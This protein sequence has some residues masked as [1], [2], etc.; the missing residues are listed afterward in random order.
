MGKYITDF[1]S[2]RVAP[3]L[4]KFATPLFLTSLL[5]VFY[6]TVDMIIVGQ[7]LEDVG[8]SAVAVGGDVTLILAFIAMGFAAAGQVIISQLIGAG[9]RQEV[10]G[11]IGTMCTVLVGSAILFTV[12]GYVFRH[13]L[14]LLMNT[15]KEAYEEALGYSTVSIFGMVFIYGY[16]AASSVLR[17]MGDA[18]RPLVFIG[19]S[20]VINVILDIVFVVW[21][22]QGATGAA[23]ATVIS[24][25]VSLVLSIIYI[26]LKRRNY[27]LEFSLKNFLVEKRH[28]ERL[29]A[30]GIPMAIKSAAVQ[31]A[32]I[33]VNSFVNSFG[34][35]VSAFSGV[36][37]KLNGIS[38][39]FSNAFNTAGA[40]MVA[41]NIGAKKYDR[42]KSVLCT[43]G[44]ITCTIA[45]VFTLVMLIFPEFVY[46]MF[47]SNA[48]VIE[49]GYTYLPIA[50]LNF[51]ASALRAVA[52]AFLN[53]SGN[54][55]ANLVTAILD[56]LVLRV[57]LSFLF[58]LALDMGAHGFWLGSA[59]TGLT[60][61]VIGAVYYFSGKWRRGR[62]LAD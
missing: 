54:T 1:T 52:N 8:L 57:G 24:Q 35:V 7:V 10:A 33:F 55:S 16:N 60:P 25:A 43:V 30:L 36:A 49:V 47:T 44:A 27:D 32:R 20:S 56:G 58:G 41:Q 40:T 53:G 18:K 61:V 46:G 59:L 13:E 6:S 62:T 51:F 37:N 17:G 23:I 45:S 48:E 34:L 31:T 12:L 28:F 22:K 29:M 3:E 50:V 42:V 9:K 39:L 11:F 38:N 26:Y 4:V 14:L 5:Q 19:I 2:G 15:P 21:L